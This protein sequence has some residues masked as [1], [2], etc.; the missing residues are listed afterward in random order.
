[1]K[2]FVAEDLNLNSRQQD[3]AN[4]HPG[5]HLAFS[6][7][8]SFSHD[9][10]FNVAVT[11]DLCDVILACIDYGFANVQKHIKTLNPHQVYIK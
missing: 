2:T 4:S 7:L 10:T 9:K 5:R 6:Q 3:C 8:E 11:L 1:M